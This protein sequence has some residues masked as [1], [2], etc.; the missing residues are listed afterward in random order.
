M[1]NENL[2]PKT[3][4]V[5]ELKN[6]IL[7]YEE[8]MKTYQTDE[9][10]NYDDLSGGDISEVKGYGPCRN[11]LCGCSCSSKE[12]VCANSSDWDKDGTG[13]SA[14]GR[15]WTSS[16]AAGAGGKFGGAMVST[17]DSSH[18]MR[19]GGSSIGGEIEVN[20]EGIDIKAELGANL[21]EYKSDGLHAK[22][23]INAD[24]G[25]T[26]NSDGVEAKLLGIGISVGKK[27]GISTPFFTISKDTDDC[28]IQ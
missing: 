11:S 12:C 1:V 19:L 2:T 4:M 17:R 10:L 26:I 7:S 24:T 23:G 13:F 20:S 3:E 6:E 15:T 28:V 14:S 21:Y 27:T 5:Y 9:N 16:S 22:I 18:E 8:F 25:A